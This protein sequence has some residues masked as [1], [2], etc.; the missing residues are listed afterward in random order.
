[1]RDSLSYSDLNNPMWEWGEGEEERGREGQ[2]KEREEGVDFCRKKPWSGEKNEWYSI[3]KWSD[4][5]REAEIV[6]SYNLRKDR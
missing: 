3:H 4:G 2:G 1:M 6:H 5:C